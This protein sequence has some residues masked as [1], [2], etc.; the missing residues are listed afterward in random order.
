[1]SPLIK[2]D[3]IQKKREVEEPKSKLVTIPKRI[4]TISLQ[5]RL[6]EASDNRSRTTKQPSSNSPNRRVGPSKPSKSRVGLVQLV[7][8][9]GWTDH[10]VQ[11][12]HLT[13]WTNH[14]VQLAYLASW[15]SPTR[16]LSE[17]DR[18]SCLHPILVA[19]SSV[20]GSN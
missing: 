2:R 16:H 3:K 10:A 19:P 20:I 13:S 1:M 7:K 6:L 8:R 5:E 17:L 14:A 15:T 4:H 11:I 12:A 18:L 9:A